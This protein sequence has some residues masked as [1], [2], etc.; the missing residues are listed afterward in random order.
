MFTSSHKNFLSSGLFYFDSCFYVRWQGPTFYLL[1]LLHEY[2][3]S[4]SWR[5]GEQD[6]MAE[7]RTRLDTKC[8]FIN[9]LNYSH[10]VWEPWILFSNK[11]NDLWKKY[12]P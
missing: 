12:V 4:W 5:A 2:F 1:R 8:V 3:I 11:K 7:N 6:L 9:S 10:Q